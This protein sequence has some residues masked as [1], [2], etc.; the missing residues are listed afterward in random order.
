MVVVVRAVKLVRLLHQGA[1]RFELLWL[2]LQEVRAV[3]HNIQTNRYGTS[4]S[5]SRRLK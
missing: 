2:G 4:E 3:G 1:V 5:K